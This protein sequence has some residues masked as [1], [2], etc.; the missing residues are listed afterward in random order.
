MR[1]H[2][3]ISLIYANLEKTSAAVE[4]QREQMRAQ[5]RRSSAAVATVGDTP[6][7]LTPINSINNNCR[8]PRFY[9]QNKVVQES[10]YQTVFAVVARLAMLHGVFGNRIAGT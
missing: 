1:K 7:P 3:L 4:G 5:Q 8:S 9:W 6:A 2:D 10:D